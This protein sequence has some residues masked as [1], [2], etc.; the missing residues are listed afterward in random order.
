MMTDTNNKLIIILDKVYDK[1]V[2]LHQ[3]LH[4]IQIMWHFNYLFILRV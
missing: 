2:F 1:I 3:W 4:L